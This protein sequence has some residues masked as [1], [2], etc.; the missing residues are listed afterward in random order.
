MTTQLRSVSFNLDLR[1]T[2]QSA[3]LATEEPD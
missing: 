3:T 1:G 2:H